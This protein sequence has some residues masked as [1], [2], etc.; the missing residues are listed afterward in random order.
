MH[1]HVLNVNVIISMQLHTRL[2]MYLHIAH[3]PTLGGGGGGGELNLQIHYYVY[4]HQYHMT[5][6]ST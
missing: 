4:E 6:Q 5:E 1:V 2:I 3:D